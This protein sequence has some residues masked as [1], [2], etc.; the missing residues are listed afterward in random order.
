MIWPVCLASFPWTLCYRRHQFSCCVVLPLTWQHRVAGWAGTRLPKGW[1]CA[2]FLQRL[3]IGLQA[4]GG[5]AIR[6]GR[7]QR[8]AKVRRTSDRQTGRWLG[9]GCLA[10]QRQ[11]LQHCHRPLTPIHSLRLSHSSACH[12]PARPPA[13]LPFILS[14]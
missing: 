1:F 8:T 11:T 5:A 14:F 7:P 6:K 10:S 9:F 13:C 12:T 2:A 3:P 4:A